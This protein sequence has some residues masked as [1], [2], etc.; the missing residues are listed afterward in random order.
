[1]LRH[2]IGPDH[3]TTLGIPVIRGRVFTPSDVDGAPRVAVI[4]E[5]FWH[6]RFAGADAAIGATLTMDRQPFT[7]VGVVPDRFGGPDVGRVADVIIPFAA[8]PMLRGKETV[9][10]IRRVWWIEVM[11]RL[12]PGMTIAQATT[13]AVAGFGRYH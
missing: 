3:F 6:S 1:M 9:L 2:Y 7:V 10:E 4:S 8:E 11:A 5:R 12:P 13:A